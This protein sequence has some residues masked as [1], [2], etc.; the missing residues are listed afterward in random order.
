MLRVTQELEAAVTRIPGVRTAALSNVVPGVRGFSNGLLP[1]GKALDLKNIT[2]TDGLMITPSYFATL[3]VPIV[4]GRAFTAADRLG[5]PLV[6]ILN[7][8]AAAQMWPGQSAIGKKLT[9]ANPL[10]PTEVVG[11]AED[12]RVGGPS[13]AAPPT[14]YVPFA[15]LNDEAWSWS[16]SVFV[17]ARTEAEPATIGNAVRQ[18]IANVDPGI[19]LFSTLTIEERMASTIA[20]ARFNTMLLVILGGAGLLLA[21]VGIYGVIGYFA[22]QR[23]SEIGIRMALGASRSDVMRLVVRQAAAPVL[24]GILLGAIGAVFATSVIASQLVDVT[25]TDPLTFTAV[26]AGL[27]LVALTAALIPA[28]RAASIDPTRA[29]HAP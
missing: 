24:A 3:Q 18:A 10:G 29:L 5:T 23:T 16:R 4:Q 7:R 8:T 17:M 2:Q 13:A 19:P 9:S 1:E 11:I 26:A 12:V 27:L 21:A 20:T 28:R 25:P 14:F 6:V 15:Q 22:T